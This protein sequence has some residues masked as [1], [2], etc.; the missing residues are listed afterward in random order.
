MTESNA[1]F[2]IVIWDEAGFMLLNDGPKGY[3]YKNVSRKDYE[4]LSGWCRKGWRGRVYNFLK[5]KRIT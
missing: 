3:W 1:R 5:K 4:T 2:E